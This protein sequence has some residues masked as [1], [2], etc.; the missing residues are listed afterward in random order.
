MDIQA[1]DGLMVDVDPGYS[2]VFLG[3][4]AEPGSE[5]R[6]ACFFD[7]RG[8]IATVQIWHVK[9]DVVLTP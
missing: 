9:A 8:H 7:P 1:T 2:K 6:L 5:G 3:G 4:D